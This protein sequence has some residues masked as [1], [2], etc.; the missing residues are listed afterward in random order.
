MPDTHEKRGA[1]IDVPSMDNCSPARPA[2]PKSFT[3]TDFAIICMV[4]SS[5]Y[6]DE[7]RGQKGGDN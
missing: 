2:P 4:H 7:E 6:S 1:D 5:L 3:A